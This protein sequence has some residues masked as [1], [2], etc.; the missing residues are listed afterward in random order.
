MTNVA[1]L[2]TVTVR[3]LTMPQSLKLEY[4]LEGF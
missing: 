4:I 3:L 2:D 1:A